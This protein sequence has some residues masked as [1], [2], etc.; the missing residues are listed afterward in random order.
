MQ[1]QPLATYRSPLCGLLDS[2]FSDGLPEVFPGAMAPPTNIA[3]TPD[4]LLVSFELPGIDE[5]DIQLNVHDR[6]LT[7][8][9]ERKDARDDAGTQGD[10]TWHRVEQR[11]GQLSRTIILPESANPEAVEATYR[12]GV[13]DVKIGKH[14]KSRPVRVAIKGS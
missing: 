3:E 14:A 13:L 10:A 12:N 6:R 1:T 5:K 7:V 8:S 2:F 9:A 4:A 11:F